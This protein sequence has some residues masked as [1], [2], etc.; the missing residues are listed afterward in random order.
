MARSSV[1]RVRVRETTA[2]VP[3][4]LGHGDEALQ[5]VLAGVGTQGWSGG[6]SVPKSQTK[7]ICGAALEVW[8]GGR[9][10]G[11]AHLWPPGYLTGSPT[12]TTSSS[13]V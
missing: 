5:R 2:A 4:L 7:G 13:S 12:S 3:E 9:G 1:G 8:G 6:F 10:R 11:I